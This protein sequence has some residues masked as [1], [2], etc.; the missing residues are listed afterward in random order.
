MLDCQNNDDE[1]K[2]RRALKQRSVD[3]ATEDN[4]RDGINSSSSG[5]YG[6]LIRIQ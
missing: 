2:S 3:R 6:T 1:R 5:V 4:S